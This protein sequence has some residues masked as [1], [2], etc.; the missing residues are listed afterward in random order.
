MNRARFA[1]RR[2]ARRRRSASAARRCSLRPA[3]ATQ[4]AADDVG[5]RGQEVHAADPGEAE[6]E[7]TQDADQARRHDA[8]H[9][10]SGEEHVARRRSRGCTID[11]TWYDKDGNIDSRRQGR[12]QRPAAAGRDPDHRD[13]DA[14][15]PE[16]DVE[17][18]Q[19]SHA[20]GTVKP[21]C[22]KSLDAPAEGAGDQ[23]G[24][25]PRSRSQKF[26]VRSSEVEGQKQ[27]RGSCLCTVHLTAF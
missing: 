23:E 15:Q 7:F 5:A 20:N 22:V 4:G 24:G 3:H 19:F 12:H 9:Q 2:D 10:D 17:Q 13:Q 11:E 16:D 6:V 18:L 21:P 26:E 27:E 8:R 1:V 25:R 14:V